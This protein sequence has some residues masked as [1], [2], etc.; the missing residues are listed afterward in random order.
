MRQQ[1]Q[2]AD[3]QMKAQLEAAQQAFEAQQNDLD[4]QLETVFKQI[5]AENEQ[6]REQGKASLT[7][8][9]IQAKMREA[10]DKRKTELAINTQKIKSTER[11]VNMKA[12]S[13]K[14]PK[15]P[16]EP[17]QKAKPGMSYQQ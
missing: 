1:S 6:L 17:P 15:P 4:R 10:I 11:L 13:D 3:R 9:Q 8:S 7:A 5:D 16:V 12:S 2:E 14:L